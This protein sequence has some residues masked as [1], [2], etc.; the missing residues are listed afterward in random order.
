MLIIPL[1]TILVLVLFY[2]DLSVFHKKTQTIS[3]KEALAWTV[4]W[5]LLA[6]IF[7]VGVYYFYEHHWFGLGK[8]IGH[9]LTGQQAAV[10]FFTGYIIEKSLSLDNRASRA[11]C[12]SY[13]SWFSHFGH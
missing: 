2:L 1:F 6:L 10:L 12:F 8:D 11:S 9:E 13:S 5:V 7:N 3:T 4:F